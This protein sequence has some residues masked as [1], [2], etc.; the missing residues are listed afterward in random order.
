MTPQIADVE[1]VGYDYFAEKLNVQQRTIRAYAAGTKAARLDYF[2]KPA[3]PRGY[4]QPLFLK[5]DAD[6]FIA[7]RRG[8]SGAAYGRGRLKPAAL[9][10]KQRAARSEAFSILGGPINLDDHRPVRSVIY[11]GLELPV[12][13]TTKKG[14]LASVNTTT[15]EE[16]YKQTGHPFLYQLLT[17]RGVNIDPVEP[18]DPDVAT[19]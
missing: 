14:S 16:L 12:L 3:T 18:V 7:E 2:P 10:K 5:A 17:Y 19:P 1:L 4:R 6:Q 8:R 9:T 13:H 11:L 15:I